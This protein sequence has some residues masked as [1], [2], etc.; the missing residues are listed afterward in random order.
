VYDHWLRRSL[1]CRPGR[2]FP[3]LCQSQRDRK[4]PTTLRLLPN[5]SSLRLPCKHYLLKRSSLL[6]N[7]T[8]Y[9]HSKT[10]HREA[11]RVLGQASYL[12]LLW[13]IAQTRRS[14]WS[15]VLANIVPPRLYLWLPTDRQGLATL[16]PL[17]H[18]PLLD[19]FPQWALTS[20]ISSW[21]NWI[22][23]GIVFTLPGRKW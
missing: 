2:S 18:Q 21:S 22:R 23:F 17:L 19:C 11:H 3:Q 20:G 1:L 16:S 6:L 15:Y 8:R 12:L 5:A 7:L 9:R 13:F 10:H 14:D 4:R